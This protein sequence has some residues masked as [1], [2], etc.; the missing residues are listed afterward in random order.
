MRHL[1]KGKKFGRKKSERRAFLKT[2]AANFIKKEKILTTEARA[3][4]LRGIVER[5]VGYG[6]NQ[7]LAGLRLL[8][9]SLPKEAAYKM[10]HEIAPR[11]AS[12]RGGY[13]RIVKRAKARQG[14]GAKMA[15]IEFV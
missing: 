5:M 8:M 14:D 4:E 6:K 12:R 2:L 10:Y 15:T 3:K 7:N 9:K 13:T 11:Y 1:S